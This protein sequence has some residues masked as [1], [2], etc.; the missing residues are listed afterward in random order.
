MIV[1][2]CAA[3]ETYRVHLQCDKVNYHG[4]F[5]GVSPANRF[6]IDRNGLCS[7]IDFN[8]K[9]APEFECRIARM[10]RMRR[11]S[12]TAGTILSAMRETLVRAI[13][14]TILHEFRS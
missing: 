10:S 7:V 5:R 6:Y 13:A 1:R 8:A 11:G 2:V 9:K 4:I 14:I 3:G 12:S